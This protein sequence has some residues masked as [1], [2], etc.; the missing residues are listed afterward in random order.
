[1][2][3]QPPFRVNPPDPF[4]GRSDEFDQN[5]KSDELRA[6]LQNLQKNFHLL[7][8]WTRKF[9]PNVSEQDYPISMELLI[10]CSISFQKNFERLKEYID[11]KPPPNDL[12]SA[13]EVHAEIED[14]FKRKIKNLT[15]TPYWKIDDFSF[16]Y[17]FFQADQVVMIDLKAMIKHLF[18]EIAYDRWGQVQRIFEDF[19]SLLA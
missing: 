4:Q 8:D 5:E 6:I 12:N 14:L 1:M 17:L 19:S 13:L 10:A 2:E 3:I 9:A 18:K 15:F 16:E 11:K 7:S